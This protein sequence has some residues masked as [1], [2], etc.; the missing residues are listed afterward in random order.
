M[1]LPGITYGAIYD[2]ARDGGMAFEMRPVRES[3]VW[4]ADEVWLS[5]STKEVVAIV[6]L[7]GRPVGNPSHTGKPGPLF[8][9]MHALFQAAKARL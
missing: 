8:K 2:F 6:T 1:I 5:S 4:E 3:E 7:D 9:R